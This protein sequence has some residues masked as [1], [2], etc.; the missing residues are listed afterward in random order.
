MLLG[1]K[2]KKSSTTYENPTLEDSDVELE[3]VE[4]FSEQRAEDAIDNPASLEDIRKRGLDKLSSGQIQSPDPEIMVA[5]SMDS[6]ELDAAFERMAESYLVSKK[7]KAAQ[8]SSLMRLLLGFMRAAHWLHWTSHWQVH[9]EN[10]YSDHKLMKKLYEGI[11]DEIDTLAEKIVAEFGEQAVNPLEQSYFLM[12]FVN[13]VCSAQEHPIYRAFLVEKSIQRILKVTY[14]KV[15]KLGTLSL[16]LDDFL[17][18]T[19]NN[20]ET[21]LYLLTQRTKPNTK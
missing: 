20:H 19:A 3:E 11:T 7:D 13:D 8:K 1:R 21:Y 4:L 18:A 16:G 5:L 17:M 15:K 2:S 14:D 10:Y 12:G 9:G 6:S